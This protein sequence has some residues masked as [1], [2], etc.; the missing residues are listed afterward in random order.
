MNNPYQT[1][2]S[3]LKPAELAESTQ[4]TTPQFKFQ[5]GDNEIVGELSL[6]S[7]WE[8][9]YVNGEQLFSKLNW[10][11][12]GVHNLHFDDEDYQLVFMADSIFKPIRSCALEKDGVVLKQYR[13]ESKPKLIYMWL[14]LA[15]VFIEAVVSGIVIDEFGLAGW[16][17]WV[18]I[19]ITFSI[20]I[21]GI[22]YGHKYGSVMV[23]EEAV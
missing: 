13:S 19:L 16:W 9:V 23:T 11:R 14:G 1:P 12:K 5:I 8:R 7:G 15:L 4:G 20:L 21:A 3:N 18:S 6:I 2:K 17:E 22:N 10:R